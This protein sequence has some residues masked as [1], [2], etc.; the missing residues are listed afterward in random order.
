[1]LLGIVKSIAESEEVPTS[2][3]SAVLLVR[4]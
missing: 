1:M 4:S 3:V 2:I